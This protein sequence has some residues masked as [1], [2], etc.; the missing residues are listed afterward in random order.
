[1]IHWKPFF[2]DFK[3]HLGVRQGPLLQAFAK[4][5]CTASSDVVQNRLGDKAAAVAFSGYSVKNSECCIWKD[6]V[7]TLAHKKAIADD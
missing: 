2:S 5:G 3:I 4:I 7:D 6:D 1:L